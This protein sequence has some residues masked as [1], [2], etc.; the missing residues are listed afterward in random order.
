MR[1][2][3]ISDI[4]SNLEALLAVEEHM[5]NCKLDRVVCLGDIV[6][7][8]AKPYECIDKVKEISHQV[9]AGNHDWAPV[10]K[11]DISCF[12]PYAKEAI[13]WT[14]ESLGPQHKE[15]LR[16]LPLV[17]QE[18]DFT[19]VHASLYEP[20]EFHYLD[21]YPSVYRDFLFLERAQ[22]KVLFLGHT[23]IPTVFISKAENLYR[24]YS[25]RVEFSPK[26]SYIVNV[27]SVGQPR[28]RDPRACFCIFDTEE[29]SVEFVRLEYDIKK[30]QEEIR[31]KN[32]PAILAKRLEAGW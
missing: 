1:I 9:L 30:T 5:K 12:N 11:V 4:H 27:G 6:G 25:P 21:S 7:Y 23:H 29:H 26:Y 32:L 31:S 13:L 16:G 28:D 14:K 18:L 10:D 17:H 8:A 3:F 2:G 19:C 20:D 22:S 15:Y 24:D